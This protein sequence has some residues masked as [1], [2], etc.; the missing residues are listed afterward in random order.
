MMVEDFNIIITSP[1][2]AVKYITFTEGPTKTR[3][4]GLRIAHRAVAKMF[5]TGGERCYLIKLPV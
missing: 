1:D 5:A 4:G 2:S 3:Q